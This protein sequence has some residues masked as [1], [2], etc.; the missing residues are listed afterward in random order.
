MAYWHAI[1]IN[2]ALLIVTWNLVRHLHLSPYFPHV[3]QL[4]LASGDLVLNED[5]TESNRKKSNGQKLAVLSM[6]QSSNFF[7]RNF[8]ACYFLSYCA[9]QDKGLKTNGKK[10]L[11]IP[12]N[13]FK[14]CVFLC[15]SGSGS[16]LPVAPC[17]MSGHHPRWTSA[18]G[19]GNGRK[20]QSGTDQ[21]EDAVRIKTTCRKPCDRGGTSPIHSTCKCYSQK[22]PKTLMRGIFC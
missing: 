8:L 16:R 6:K 17:A 10:K 1:Q 7:S 13:K 18:G 9:E 4:S 11:I 2:T 14:H 12:V 19:G 21:L 3:T 5:R 15:V 20:T 22:N